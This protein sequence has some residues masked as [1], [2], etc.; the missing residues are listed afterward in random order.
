[1]PP[2]KSAPPKTALIELVSAAKRQPFGNHQHERQPDP[3]GRVD[4]V[5]TERN[6]HQ[7]ACRENFIHRLSSID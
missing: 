7:G 3:D 6:T 2:P 1:M 4:D 5:E